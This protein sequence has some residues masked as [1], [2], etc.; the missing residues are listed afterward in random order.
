MSNYDYYVVGAGDTGN[1][2]FKGDLSF[3]DGLDYFVEEKSLTSKL[4]AMPMFPDQDLDHS[5]NN[6]LENIIVEINSKAIRFGGLYAVGEKA[7]HVGRARNMNISTGSKHTDELPILTTLAIIAVKAVQHDFKMNEKLARELY[8]SVDY[9]TAIPAREYTKKAAHSLEEKYLSGEHIVVVHV[10]E[11]DYV[12]VKI[13]FNR[14]KV[15]QEGN[16]ASYAIFYGDPEMLYDFKQDYKDQSKVTNEYFGDKKILHVDIGDGTTEFVYTVAGRP[17]ADQSDGERYGVGHAAVQA[18]KAF[19]DAINVQINMNRQQFM[20]AV[21][22]VTHIQHEEAK[23]AMLEASIDQSQA[24]VEKVEEMYI[25][26][27]KGDVEIVT[28]FGGGSAQ[29]KHILKDMMIELGERLNFKVLWIPDAF[30]AKINAMG[31]KELNERVFF[32]LAVN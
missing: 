29:F 23:S 2:K 6:L 18:L 24:I 15:T 21:T 27:L 13:N 8:I 7:S 19:Q 10:T 16:P 32:K 17:I 25:D 26:V 14:V 9:S 22:D 28:V 1:S 3:K 30:S 12:S 4:S 31:L 11:D 20:D 5:V